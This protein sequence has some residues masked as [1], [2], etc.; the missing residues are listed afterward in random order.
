MD[1][2]AIGAKSIGH[3]SEEYA[4]A[5][6]ECQ[7]RECQSS[8]SASR[9]STVEPHPKGLP[10]LSIERAFNGGGTRPLDQAVGH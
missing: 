10:N 7:A 6:E 8:A 1:R 2:C 5:L 4:N 9:S 3:T